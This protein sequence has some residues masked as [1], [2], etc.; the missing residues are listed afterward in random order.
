MLILN[1][2]STAP[3]LSLIPSVGPSTNTENLFFQLS[4]SGD[5]LLS[6]SKITTFLAKSLSKLM[7]LLYQM[8]FTEHYRYIYFLLS[9]Y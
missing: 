9:S 1:C 7:N 5:E 6:T 3:V 4:V 2:F 8:L